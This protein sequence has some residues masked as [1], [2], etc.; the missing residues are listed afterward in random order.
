MSFTISYNIKAIDQ[1]TAVSQR[2]NAAISDID[3]NIKSVNKG[4]VGL[5]RSFGAMAVASTNAADKINK[6]NDGMRK[7]RTQSRDASFDSTML[8]D[9]FRRQ[10]VALSD[11]NNFAKRN[12]AATK[13][14]TQKQ[15]EMN[16]VQA[17]AKRKINAANR[18]MRDRIQLQRQFGQGMS[19]F[20]WMV[21]TRVTLPLLAAGGASVKFAMDFNK[22]MANVGTL[23]PGQTAKLQKYKTE[24]LDMSVQYGKSADIVSAGLYQVISNVGDTA[25]TM[26]ILNIANKAAVAGVAETADSVNLLTGIASDYGNVSADMVQRLSD[27][28]FKTVELGSTTFP[29]LAMQ[30]GKT[31]TLAATLGVGVDELFGSFAGLTSG[32]VRTAQVSTRLAGVMR[33]LLN[34]A[35][36]LGDTF[37]K[38]GV[39]SGDQ[40]I[41]KY[42][43]LQ[44]ALFAIRREVGNNEVAFSKLFVDQ[45]AKLAALALT[46]AKSKEAAREIALMSKAA[47]ASETAFREQSDGINAAGFRMEQTMQRIKRMSI[48]I[49][50]RL[51][52]QVEKLM[53]AAEPWI[54]WISKLDQGTID[55]A[56]SF[57]KWAAIIGVGSKAIGASMNMIAWGQQIKSVQGLTGALGGLNTRIGST[58]QLLGKGGMLITAFASGWAVGRDIFNQ[59]N[60]SILELETR[61]QNSA[62][63]IGLIAHKLTSKE[64]EVKLSEQR[65]NIKEADS[66][67][68]IVKATFTGNLQGHIEAGQAARQAEIDLINEQTKRAKERSKALRMFLEGKTEYPAEY[69][70]NEAYQQEKMKNALASNNANVSG[71]ID[72]RVSTDSGS[73]AEVRERK[74]GNYSIKKT[75]RN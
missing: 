10:S 54:D 5:S 32:T 20:G 19:R 52:P 38:L 62:S 27:L 25:D 63:R 12:A 74:K 33:A 35:G 49:G 9:K 60:D 41:K 61:I 11:L 68:N 13:L 57:A 56:L 29:E 23:I 73:K 30:M 48:S 71:A 1:F 45:E 53:I 59:W 72:I 67:F 18:A 65:R 51:L 50:D 3:R 26:Q 66:W 34:G 47:G 17:E 31:T 14:A 36:D 58:A 15:R 55:A 46:G 24:V 16:R 64:I 4:N 37:K 75:G 8:S 42:G 21:N 28:A 2:I 40:L 69:G 44:N 43:G 39:Q 70:Q 7:L 22:S 6:Q